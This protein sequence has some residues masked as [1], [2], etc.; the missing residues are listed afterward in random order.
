MKYISKIAFSIILS[1]TFFACDTEETNTNLENESELANKQMIELLNSKLGIE[2]TIENGDFKFTYPDGRFLLAISSNEN[3]TISGTRINN[4]TLVFNKLSQD[5]II[6]SSNPDVLL[7]SIKKQ[8]FISTVNDVSNLKI[9]LV[10]RPC[11][12]HPSNEDFDDCFKR[13]WDEFCDGF[14]GCLAQ[15]TN[16]VLI[17]AVIAGHCAAC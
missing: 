16:P 8:D 15:A 10:A 14:I 13:E 9:G 11:N 4:E 7:K 2:T 12:Q 6:D 3:I 1:L 17:A 5:E